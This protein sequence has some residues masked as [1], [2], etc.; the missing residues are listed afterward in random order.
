MESGKNREFFD[1]IGI[2]LGEVDE[3]FMTLCTKLSV[4]TNLK[5]LVCSG[6]GGNRIHN[7]IS[8][9]IKNY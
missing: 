2:H 5:D 4:V 8:N 3:F 1:V 7:S 9:V 6:M